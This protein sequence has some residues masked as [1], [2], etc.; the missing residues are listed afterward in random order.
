L[1]KGI[2]Y[3]LQ[4]NF[5]LISTFKPCNRLAHPSVFKH[6]S[7]PGAPNEIGDEQMKQAVVGVRHSA[8][9][10][11][12]LWFRSA[13]AGEMIAIL[14]KV[15]R[16]RYSSNP[17]FLTQSRLLRGASEV[18]VWKY[19]KGGKIEPF[20]QMPDNLGCDG[21]QLLSTSFV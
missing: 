8:S 14:Q 12:L 7:E 5:N 16:K 15:I 19:S 2:D 10:T 1:R 9:Q 11:G 17:S 6:A 4:V 21:P 18:V 13:T 20:G 3:L